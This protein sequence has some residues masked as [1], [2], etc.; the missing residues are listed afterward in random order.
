MNWTGLKVAILIS[1]RFFSKGVRADTLIAS[2]FQAALRG[3]FQFGRTMWQ[4]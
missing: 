3:N 1:A 2:G 4:V